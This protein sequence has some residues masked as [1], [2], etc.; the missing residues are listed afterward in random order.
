MLT[1]KDW[2]EEGHLNVDNFW[3]RGYNRNTEW[4]QAFEDGANRPKGYSRGYLSWL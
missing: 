4:Q 3:T 2:I 1:A